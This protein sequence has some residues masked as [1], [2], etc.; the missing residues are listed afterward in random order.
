[1]KNDDIA[2]GWVSINRQIHKKKKKRG[3]R[4]L[5]R[6]QH[7]MG[8]QPRTSVLNMKTQKAAGT[9]LAKMLLGQKGRTKTTAKQFL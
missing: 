4:V 5:G 1:M 7:K 8:F 9:I 6:T 3:K 2:W